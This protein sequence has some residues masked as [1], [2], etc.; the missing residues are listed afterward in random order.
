MSVNIRQKKT[1]RKI[2][3]HDTGVKQNKKHIHRSK[4]YYYTRSSC[5]MDQL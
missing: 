3:S 1:H 4:P 5:T 2:H